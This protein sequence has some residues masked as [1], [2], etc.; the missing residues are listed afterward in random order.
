MVGCGKD[1]KTCRI[2]ESGTKIVE[3]RNVTFVATL[4][5]KRN[6]FDHDHNDSNDDTFLD[7]ESSFISLGTQ[8]E[9]PETEAGAEPDTSDSQSGGTISN[10]DEKSDNDAVSYTHLTL[11]T[12]REV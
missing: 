11:P 8:E 1:S 6:A 9:M 10:V 2:W 3:S 7:P 5:V 12:N 4:P